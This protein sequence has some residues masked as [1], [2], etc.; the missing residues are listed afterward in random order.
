MP[1]I[2]GIM[3]SQKMTSK[4]SQRGRGRPLCAFEA[5]FDIV[6][7]PEEERERAR[8]E[9]VVVYDQNAAAAD[10]SVGRGGRCHCP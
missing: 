6:V 2:S 1:V 7:A 4:R 10:R 5:H 8:D 3:R 9:R